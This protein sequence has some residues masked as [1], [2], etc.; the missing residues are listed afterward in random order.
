MGKKSGQGHPEG[1]HHPGRMGDELP[2]AYVA[3]KGQGVLNGGD[4][5]PKR[6]RD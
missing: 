3:M 4:G 2:M 5:G 6:D 1:E